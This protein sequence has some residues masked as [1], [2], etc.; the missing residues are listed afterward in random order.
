MA[1]NMEFV[2]QVREAVEER[3]AGHGGVEVERTRAKWDRLFKK[4][5][6]H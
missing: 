3:L 5:A 2:E 1:V 6:A 4:A